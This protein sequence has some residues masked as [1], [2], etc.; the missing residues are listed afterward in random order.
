MP[1]EFYTP[2]QL[3]EMLQVSKPAVYK[4][5]Q[6]GRIEVVRIGRTVRIP[7]AEVDRLLSEGRSPRTIG[8]S[9]AEEQPANKYRPVLAAA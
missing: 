3:A 1:R 9:P 8:S 4:W 5:A 6:E 2:E 7:V